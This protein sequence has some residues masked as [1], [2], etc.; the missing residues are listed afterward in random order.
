MLAHFP[1]WQKYYQMFLLGND[2]CCIVFEQN[3]TMLKQFWLFTMKSHLTLS[4]RSA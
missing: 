3:D 4:C 1:V 2:R